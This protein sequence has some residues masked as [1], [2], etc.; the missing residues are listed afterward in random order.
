[1]FEPATGKERAV[2]RGHAEAIRAAAFS[3]DGIRL[4]TAGADGQ[5]RLWGLT[6]EVQAVL[7]GHAGEVS[8]LAFS[9]DGRRLASGG[10]DGAR[11]WELT[12]GESQAQSPSRYVRSPWI[13]GERLVLPVRS[14]GFSLDGKAL[15]V[16]ADAPWEYTPVG[17]IASWELNLD[18]P[19]A[20]YHAPPAKK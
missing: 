4:A 11:T 13:P 16:W 8:S 19:D 15:W 1:L 3:P 10:E 9:P 17:A 7:R 20:I 12:A 2:L 18:R 14:L 5:V 6:G